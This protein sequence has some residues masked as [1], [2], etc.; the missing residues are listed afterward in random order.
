MKRD[1]VELLDQKN[2]VTDGSTFCGFNDAG[3]RHASE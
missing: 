3:V 1:S 2:G